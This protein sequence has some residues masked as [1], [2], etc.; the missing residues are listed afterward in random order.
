M[1]VNKY[2]FKSNKNRFYQSTDMIETDYALVILEKTVSL[3]IGYLGLIS[4]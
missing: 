3:D 4:E 1:I 2:S